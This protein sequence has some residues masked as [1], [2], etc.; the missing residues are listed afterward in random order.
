MNKQELEDQLQK[1]NAATIHTSAE[2]K[3]NIEAEMNIKHKPLI[4]QARA[5]AAEINSRYDSIY[6]KRIA[7]LDLKR[8]E[9]KNELSKIRIQEANNIWYP[10]GTIVH[11]W[12]FQRLLGSYKRSLQKTEKTGVVIVYD[13]TQSIRSVSGWSEPAFGDII[14]MHHKKDGSLG[15]NF[16][17][18]SSYG[19]ISLSKAHWYSD[20]DT[21]TDNIETRK[22]KE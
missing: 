1:V 8:D 4:E 9:L 11:L 15:L 22:E 7:E 10:K 19:H 20:G 2:K 6:E 14:V 18:I 5:I 17:K 12:E 21:P 3:S 16:D 13:G